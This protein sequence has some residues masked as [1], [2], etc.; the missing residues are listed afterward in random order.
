MARIRR[1][2]RGWGVQALHVLDGESRIDYGW[3]LFPLGIG[4][5]AA[6]FLWG[7]PRATLANPYPP[8]PSW[9]WP[10]IGVCLLISAVGLLLLVSP[11]IGGR[12]RRRRSG[13][14]RGLVTKT[15]TGEVTKWEDGTQDVTMTPP[16]AAAVLCNF[17]FHSLSVGLP[18]AREADPERTAQF[19]FRF[20]NTA[21]FTLGYRIMEGYVRAGNRISPLVLASDQNLIPAGEGQDYSW[22]PMEN[23]T[24][25]DLRDVEIHLVVHYGRPSGGSWFAMDCLVQ[26][27][28]SA[29]WD[30]GW[31]RNWVW[32]NKRET[33]HELT[34]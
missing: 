14:R 16:E 9:R 8:E 1:V 2:L 18:C 21:D 5:A 17:W 24:M 33:T 23:V 26:P 20:Q 31:P 12:L 11:A 22:F 7:G 15:P 6:L 25:E 4:I 32:R 19:W 29:R 10:A 34:S 28:Q 13:E 3:G 30:N 27:I